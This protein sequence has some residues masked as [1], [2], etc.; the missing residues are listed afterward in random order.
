MATLTIDEIMDTMPHRY[1][2]LL[3]DRIIECDD[4][5]RIVG[6]KNVTANE[7]FFQGHFP[8]SPIMPG[9]LQLEAMAQTGGILLMRMAGGEAGTPYFM[10][11][12][13]AKFRKV[14]RPGDQLRIEA[15]MVKRR[16]RSAKFQ[17]RILVEGEVVSEA[18]LMCMVSGK[19]PEA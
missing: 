17:A 2:M 4:E 12:D 1:P 11:I 7:P 18:E 5:R 14:V 3:I 10:S 16:T 15:E 13:K 8:Q 9:V 19:E 6:I